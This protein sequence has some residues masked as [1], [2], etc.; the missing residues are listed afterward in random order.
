EAGR[1][2]RLELARLLGEKREF[3]AAEKLLLEVRAQ[4]FERKIA[5]RA[6][7][8]LAE[9]CTRQGLLADAVAFYRELDRDFPAVIVNDGKTGKE[10]YE[11]LIT[12]KRFLPYLEDKPA[13]L[14]GL[15]YRA[16]LT[17]D[18]FTDKMLFHME[19]VGEELPFW[20][21]HRLNINFDY[22]QGRLR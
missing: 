14:P 9:L 4:R 11:G 12:D 22:M 17:P 20:R 18:G 6:V 2:A 13:F 21:E 15:K 5:G 8:Q 1:E 10:V 16:S 7:Y 19:R 3:L